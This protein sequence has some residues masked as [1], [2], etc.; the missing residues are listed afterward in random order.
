ML[1]VQAL[2]IRVTTTLDGCEP[3]HV[4]R[5]DSA[6]W[7]LGIAGAAHLLSTNLRNQAVRHF[8]AN[9]WPLPYEGPPRNAAE[10]V[11][12]SRLSREADIL[13]VKGFGIGALMASFGVFHGATVAAGW[14]LSKCPSLAVFV[15]TPFIIGAVAL[16][17]GPILLRSSVP[18]KN[19]D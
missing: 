4:M 10:K 5:F 8:Q 9:G 6:I 3:F 16:V 13:I 7:P 19:G 1:L 12:E 15:L 11:L 2:F 14:A 17:I 18:V